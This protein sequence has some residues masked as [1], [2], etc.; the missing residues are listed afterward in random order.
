MVPRLHNSP[1]IDSYTVGILFNGLLAELPTILDS[2]Y[3]SITSGDTGAVG[4]HE[5][6][7]KMHIV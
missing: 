1:S 6:A 7:G 4:S 3:T 2:F 5:V